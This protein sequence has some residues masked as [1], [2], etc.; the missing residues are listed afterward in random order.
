MKKL[1]I[2][3]TFSA[4]MVFSLA[5]CNKNTGPTYCTVTF[6]NYDE[7]IL[8]QSSV[9]VGKDVDYEGV[10]PSR[11]NTDEFTYTF[12]GWDKSLKNIQGDS[13]RYAQY[14]ETAI[15]KTVYYDVS[16]KNYDG[17]LLYETYVEKGHDVIYQGPAA[18]KPETS[19]YTYTF[20]GWD[21]SLLNVSSDL[22]CIAQ[23][24]ETKKEVKTYYTVLFK[25]YDDTLL[26][27]TKVEAGGNATYEGSQPVR[28]ESSEY[29]YAF[30]G[31]NKSLENIQ[32]DCTIIAQFTATIKPVTTYYSVA[33]K[34]YDAT[35]LYETYVEKGHNAIYE[36]P[37]PTRKETEEYTYTFSGWDRSLQ[38][39]TSDIVCIAQYTETK[40]VIPTYYSVIFKNYD[41]SILYES[42][43]VEG[44][45]AIYGG[46]TPVRA[47]SA[48]IQ[49]TFIGWDRSLYDIR[50]N[51]VFVAQYDESIKEYTVQFLNY[52]NKLLYT[53]TV[54]YKEKAIYVGET[55]TKP[56]T[57]S[58]YYVFEGWDKDLNSIIKSMT[59]K[60]VYSEHVRSFNVTVK[61][62]NGESDRVFNFSYNDPYNFGEPEYSGYDFLGWYIDENTPIPSS[63]AWTYTDASVVTAKWG[64]ENFVF[65]D[66]GDNTYQ[67]GLSPKG[68]TA[69]EIVIPSVF[70][71]IEVTTMAANFAKGSSSTAN[72]SI[73]KITI[74]GTIKSIPVSSFDGCSNLTKVVL[75]EGLTTIGDNAFRHCNLNKLIVP[76]TCIS[77][78]SSAFD[79]N[80]SLY[81]VYIPSSVMNIGKYAFDEINSYAYICVER[82]TAPSTW[83]SG[84]TKRTI[85]YGTV[86]LVENDEYNY[87]IQSDYG[88]LSATILRLGNETKQL[89]SF[90]FPT[91]IE[92]VTNI[93]VGPSL[94]RDNKYIR[95]VDF[96]NVTKIGGYAFC[97]CTNL[98]EVTFSD[99]LVT[100]CAHAFEN[101]TSL[102]RI[103]IPNSVRRIEDFA[104]N[105]CS[106]IKYV[107]IPNNVT[108]I[109][110]YAFDTGIGT[111]IY[112][113]AHASKSGWNSSWKG[114]TNIPIYYDYVSS[115]EVSDFN[116]VVQSYLEE[117]YVTIISLK[118]SAKEKSSLVIPNEIENISDIR[119]ANSL[120]KGVTTLTSIDIG[121]GV[122]TIPTSCFENC[123]NLESVVLHE[124]LTK[125]SDKAFR[126]CSSLKRA[127]LPSSLTTIGD[128]AF[129]YC[130]SL[131]ETNIPISVT[132]IGSYAFDETGVMALLIE[133][134]TS[135]S[136]WHH[137]WYGDG[138]TTRDK[139]QLVY[140]YVSSGAIGEFRYAKA[141]N[142]V[143][144]TIYILGLVDGSLATNLVVPDEIEGISNIKIAN[145]AFSENGIL[146]TIDLGNSV[147]YISTF[148]FRNNI[149][150]ASVFIPLSCSKIMNNAFSGCKTTC[151][152]NCEASSLPSTW[153]S[154]WNNSSCQ[155]VWDYHR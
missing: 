112:S 89:Q 27:E 46:M 57:S 78:G 118:G 148:A 35:L 47:D 51:T 145:Y 43:V 126:Y 54:H 80:S 33:F 123:T 147:T 23:Y 20:S 15:P 68:I 76:N 106:G 83:V 41:G 133:A 93:I 109:L 132:T 142:G 140:D 139:K 17:T 141:S 86:K 115:G 66:N 19:E 14:I 103:E 7:S 22:V 55:P 136:G 131:K 128:F 9:E 25:N 11:A 104:F 31:W 44:G 48:E 40:K 134:S 21:H 39:I 79:Y 32:S 127:T 85:Y 1:P 110:N 152:L 29:T 30:S 92:E 130:T 105:N 6:K 135:Q 74:P 125:I 8:S 62:N 137:Y 155:V 49:Y 95:S 153:E 122:K 60:A 42:S 101:C 52:D 4:L 73:T 121:T 38:N 99:S 102:N 28:P 59:T 16:F 114:S 116:Y 149:S 58:H 37:N 124:G 34:N 143:T 120:F 119:L 151:V 81:H 82:P 97:Y 72:T 24:T 100:I 63:G 129:D 94:F 75:N 108:T 53:D 45:T 154:N 107:Y 10:T 61:P 144:D 96:A 138:S 98:T 77:I 69:A 56:S 64:Y 26:C 3:M 71:G 65:T 50:C 90:T 150:L 12:N 146:K 113:N 5:G 67:V 36:G 91:E 2:L 111:T 117:S 18:I 70:E 13:V 87:V 84:W 88:D